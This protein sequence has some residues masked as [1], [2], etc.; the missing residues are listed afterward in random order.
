MRHERDAGV[1]MEEMMAANG[2]RVAGNR[3]RVATG[4]GQ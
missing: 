3:W 1:G 4:G 2:S